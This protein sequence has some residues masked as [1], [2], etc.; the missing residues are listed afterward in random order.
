MTAS[1]QEEEE[2]GESRRTSSESVNACGEEKENSVCDTLA[3][4]MVALCEYGRAGGEG[5]R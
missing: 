1:T 5:G 3:R 2:K 4:R